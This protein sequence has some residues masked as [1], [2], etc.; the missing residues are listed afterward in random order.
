MLCQSGRIHHTMRLNW[1]RPTLFIMEIAPSLRN[2]DS[3]YSRK[4]NDSNLRAGMRPQSGQAKVTPRRR[5]T[6]KIRN[7]AKRIIASIQLYQEKK[8]YSHKQCHTSAQCQKSG[9]PSQGCDNTTD[10]QSPP[11]EKNS[12]QN[13]H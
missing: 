11:K 8:I 3:G 2:P 7:R 4:Q 12:W 10:G 13:H 6:W 5:S 1:V 9:D